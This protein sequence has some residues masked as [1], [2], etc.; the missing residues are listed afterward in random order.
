MNGIRS[1]MLYLFLLAIIL[2][3]CQKS[4]DA[5][6]QAQIEPS[7]T[8]T[9]TS[10]A[11]VTVAPSSTATPQPTSTATPTTLPSK[12][13]TATPTMTPTPEP[14]LVLLVVDQSS[15][16]PLPAAGIEIIDN[17][18][19]SSIEVESASTGQ[20]T[21][22][23]LDTGTYTLTITAAGYQAESI[24]LA[25]PYDEE[26]LTVSLVPTILAEVTVDNSNMRSGPGTSYP[27]VE[28]AAAGQQ[29]CIIGQSE[30]GQWLVVETGSGTTAWISAT[31]VDAP[32]DLSGVPISAAPPTPTPTATSDAPVQVVAAFPPAAAPP[33]GPNM[34]VNPDFE[35]GTEGWTLRNARHSFQPKTC[36]LDMYAPLVRSGYQALCS[37]YNDDMPYYQ[38]IYNVTPGVAYRFGAWVRYWS[39]TGSD[40]ALSVKPGEADVYV[41]INTDGEEDRW[42][43]STVCSYYS[44]PID[45][46]HYLSVDAIAT[47]DK[48]AVL[49]VMGFNRK[50]WKMNRTAAF[51]DASLGLAPASPTPTPP[52]LTETIRPA[53]VPFSGATLR[54]SMNQARGYLDQMG[55][56][57]DRLLRGEITT[58]DEYQEFRNYYYDLMRTAIYDGVPGDWQ[59]VYNEYIFA[60][61]NGLATNQALSTICDEDKEEG[62]NMIT[63]LNYTAGRTGV[64][65]SLNRL[66]PAI[67]TA[68]ALL[69]G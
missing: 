7:S 6:S 2:V 69:G 58:C 24:P 29:L 1:F 56:M 21:L 28:T 59:G 61:E 30:D 48:I 10:T 35:M 57:L 11:T 27:V 15:G 52:P 8:A 18:G 14:S 42:L 68:S 37:D 13:P 39:S 9:S 38:K 49:L 60:V 26:T 31:L 46:W 20:W 34:L 19:E 16:E 62:Q 41:C 5:P 45:T 55:G 23:G 36:T 43:D 33:A 22:T 54:D 47:S 3:G 40:R 66:L 67:E 12:T 25:F 32:A 64:N 63:R 44:Q 4:E 65:D 50:E 17:A 53:P 51:D